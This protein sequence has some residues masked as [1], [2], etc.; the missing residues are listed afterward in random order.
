MH[1]LLKVRGTPYEILLNYINVFID[2]SQNGDVLNGVIRNVVES[3]SSN[4]GSASLIEH[5]DFPIGELSFYS[6]NNE[7]KVVLGGGLWNIENPR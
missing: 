4:D 6:I 1:F 7:L 2:I 3:G 5:F